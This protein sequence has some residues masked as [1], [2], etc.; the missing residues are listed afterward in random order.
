MPPRL[1]TL[2]EKKLVGKRLN[3]SLADNKT[4]VLWRSFMPRWKEITNNRT[5]DLISMA[6]YQPGYFA[7]FNPTREFE[8]WAAVEVADFDSV[9]YSMLTRN[10]KKRYGF[11][12]ERKILNGKTA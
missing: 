2:K 8:K 4:G 12:C 1:S 11:R 3:M 6:V 10:R 9:P 7:D 5:T